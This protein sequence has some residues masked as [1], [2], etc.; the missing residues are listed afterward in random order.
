MTMF[1]VLSEEEAE[2]AIKWKAPD[3]SSPNSHVV[4]AR[5]TVSPVTLNA[6]LAAA[7]AD[8]PTLPVSPGIASTPTTAQALQAAQTQDVTPS[9]VSSLMSNPSVE[10]LQSSYDDGYA[11]GYAEGNKALRDVKIAELTTL[12]GSITQS[13]PPVQEDAL[14]QEIYR[15]SI[16]IARILLQREMRSEPDA[17][18]NLVKAGLEQLPSN[19]SG[20]KQVYMNP[21]DAQIVAQ[22]LSELP[23]TA[24]LIDQKLARGECRIQSDS[25]TVHAGLENWLNSM[26]TELG[27]L[28]PLSEPTEQASVAKPIE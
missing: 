9:S 17:L 22:E 15:L 26:A 27:I 2:K 5:E 8:K 10:M 7:A 4:H 13:L 20:P 28:T 25:S 16:D 19:A 14:E 24:V 3:L 1:R 21:Q 6:I 23:D 18:A 12:I 11:Q